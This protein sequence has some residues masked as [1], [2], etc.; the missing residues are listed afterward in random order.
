[1]KLSLVLV[2]A[3]VLAFGGY[4]IGRAQTSNKNSIEFLLYRSNPFII[5]S[6]LC[7][8]SSSLLPL[9]PTPCPYQR[10]KWSTYSEVP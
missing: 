5:A 10:R 1:M 4:A 7:F 6:V 9:L 3:W 2:A 8:I